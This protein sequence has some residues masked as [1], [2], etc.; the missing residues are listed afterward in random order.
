ML[1]KYRS[2]K[3]M[4]R[5]QQLKLHKKAE[6]HGKLAMVYSGS[7]DKPEQFIKYWKKDYRPGYGSGQTY[8]PGLYTVCNMDSS[9]T[10]SGD[11][12]D[13]IYQFIVNLENYL[14]LIDE[15]IDLVYPE[16]SGLSYPQK[17]LRQFERFKITNKKAVEMA[18]FSRKP[19]YFTAD[20]A[21]RIKEAG[22]HYGIVYKGRI[23]GECC[24]IQIPEQAKLVGYINLKT[25]EKKRFDKQ[26]L[27]EINHR[28]KKL[29][30]KN[31]SLKDLLLEFS[32]LYPE[33][34]LTL[35]QD[36][37]ES[38]KEKNPSADV[39]F[40]KGIKYKI[41]E[42]WGREGND[43]F[44]YYDL[45]KDDD[46]KWLAIETIKTWA[47]K[48]SPSYYSYNLNRDPDFEDLTKHF[49]DK[50]YFEKLREQRSIEENKRVEEEQQV[51]EEK[52]N[53]D[54]IE[55]KLASL[56]KFLSK[57]GFSQEALLTKQC[58]K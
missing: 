5:Y 45:H 55:E 32:E 49:G 26:E 36:H 11:Y 13:Y 6:I 1:F 24:L 20:L 12:G 42:A 41:A 44:F 43:L 18:E 27:G 56:C 53:T 46:F 29:N 25:G 37:I 23:D 31:R 47:E 38:I 50:K 4:K 15:K 40:Y 21:L 10:K 2:D 14:I 17:L 28:H 51:E 7:M 8:G 35:A 22:L 19:I 54:A 52:D 34:T 30:L 48:R 33:K 16:L 3:K 39:D 9:S 57:S 58:I